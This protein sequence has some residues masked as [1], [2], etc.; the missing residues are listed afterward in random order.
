MHKKNIKNQDKVYKNQVIYGLHSVKAALLN[1]KRTHNELILNENIN[2]PL[3]KYKSKVN[4]KT[5]NI[6]SF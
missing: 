3:E 5:S 4:K 6:S 2:F 1:E